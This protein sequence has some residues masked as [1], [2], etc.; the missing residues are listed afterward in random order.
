MSR[1]QYI[2]DRNLRF[3]RSTRTAWNVVKSTLK[4]AVA[5][6]SLAVFYYIVFALVVNTDSERKLIRENRLYERTYQEMLDRE[7]LLSDVIAGLEAKDDQI[8]EEIFHVP[9]PRMGA[10][11]SQDYLAAADTVPDYEMVEYA[12]GKIAAAEKRSARIEDNFRKALA[13]IASEDRIL[14]P[15]SLPLGSV[16]FAQV[17]ASVG[18][19]VN[20]FYKV[21]TAHNGVD[22]IA[23]Q[24]DP[25]LAVADGTVTDIINERK[26]LGNVV[27]IT[28]PGGYVTRYAHLA[29]IKVSRGQRVQ[30]GRRIASVGISGNS[31]APHLHFELLKDGEYLD[32]VDGFFA[33]VTPEEYAEMKLMAS[34]TGQS[35]D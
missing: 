4:Y 11:L 5:T 31:F 3:R 1:E 12:Y 23:P 19:K 30:R 2:I 9:A 18:Q 20:P 7:R 25:V 15:M 13:L 10:L 33:D 29:D 6:V 34:R 35:L 16:S 27:E 32:P 21:E 28:P 8:Y 22:L 14:P 24:G 26:G 17:G